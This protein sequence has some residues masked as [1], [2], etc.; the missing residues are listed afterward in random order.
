MGSTPLAF[1][2]YIPLGAIALLGLFLLYLALFRDRSK[3]RRRCPKCWYDMSGA[4]PTPPVR[5]PECG[6]VSPTERDLART[7]R[8]WPLAILAYIL[9]VPLL[10]FFAFRDGTR[11]YYALAPKWKLVEEIRVNDTRARRYIIRNPNDRG[12][13]ALITSQGNTILDVQDYDVQFGQELPF[14]SNSPPPHPRLGAGEDLNGNGI[15]DVVIFAYS[16]GAHCCY[17][18]H[19]VELSDPPLIAATIDARNGMG[20]QREI[21]GDRDGQALFNISDQSFDYWNAPHASSPA[22]LVFYRLHNHHLEI[23]LDMMLRPADRITSAAA[24]GARAEKAATLRAALAKPDAKLDVQLW[25]TMLTLVYQG[26]EPDAL[27]FLD[28]AWPDNAPPDDPKSIKLSDE[29]PPLRSAYPSKESFKNAF[30]EVLAKSPQYQDLKAA[31]AA[32]AAGQPIPPATI[33]NYKPPTPF[34]P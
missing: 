32:A 30:F 21:G 25:S 9:M 13:R 3:S 15:P 27:T 6:H 23:A 33:G 26:Y 8:R 17:T 19:I 12:G 4:S 20:I 22:P 2:L 5:C 11:A 10:A 34:D 7:R 29:F 1:W 28:N 24:I 18:V 31:Q 16:G 14:F